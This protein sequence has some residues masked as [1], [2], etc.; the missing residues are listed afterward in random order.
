LIEEPKSYH[1]MSNAIN[2][3]GDGQ[4]AQRIVQ[5]LL[6]QPMEGFG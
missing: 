4:A 5:F 3:Y 1:H 6:G 2:P